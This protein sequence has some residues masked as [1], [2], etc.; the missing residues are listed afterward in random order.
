MSKIR[1]TKK[2]FSDYL[3]KNSNVA[4]DMITQA[5]LGK[6]VEDALANVPDEEPIW[7]D[8]KY[9]YAASELVKV[10]ETEDLVFKIWIDTNA[11]NDNIFIIKGDD[12]DYFMKAWIASD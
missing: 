2:N 5:F 8:T 10:E 12:F 1:L 3:R 11:K 7:I 4:V 6:K 9:V